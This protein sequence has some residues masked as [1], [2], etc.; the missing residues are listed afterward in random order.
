MEFVVFLMIRL[1]LGFLRRKIT[2]VQCPFHHVASRLHTMNM[3]YH[4]DIDLAHLLEVVFVKLLR[5]ILSPV[6]FPLSILYSLGVPLHSP[7]LRSRE[8]SSSSFMMEYLHKLF[9]MPLHRRFVSSLQF[10]LITYL[11][12]DS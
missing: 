12:Q 5:S 3:T 1:V 10:I 9:G 6:H 7:Y 8:L 11:C 4:V 2:E